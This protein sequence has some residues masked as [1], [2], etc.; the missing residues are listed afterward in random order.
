MN[1]TT[2]DQATL[3]SADIDRCAQDDRYQ[4]WGYLAD[5]RQQFRHVAEAADQVVL[6]EAARQGW[7]AETLFHWTNSVQG[8]WFADLAFGN[9]FWTTDSLTAAAHEQRL[10]AGGFVPT[11]D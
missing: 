10:F 5:R 6:A 1:D 8:R 2:T 7:S 4:G 9:P 11:E 3:T